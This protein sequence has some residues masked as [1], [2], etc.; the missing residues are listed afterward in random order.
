[1]YSFH[2][3]H[4]HHKALSV[5]PSGGTRKARTAPGDKGGLTRKGGDE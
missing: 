5:R 3:W 1:V 4:H 2:C